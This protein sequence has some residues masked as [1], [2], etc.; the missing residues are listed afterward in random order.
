MDHST[1]AGYRMAQQQQQEQAREHEVRARIAERSEAQTLET[2]TSAAAP[3]QAHGLAGAA[4]ARARGSPAHT[5]ITPRLG[6]QGRPV[7]G[8]GP[9]PCPRDVLWT[10]ETVA[11]EARRG[12][13]TRGGPAA[14]LRVGGLKTGCIYT[15]LIGSFPV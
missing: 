14:C 6:I 10:S 3:A 5:L 4:G 12:R 8:G 2:G 7:Q 9:S 11:A 15:G 1:W 13:P